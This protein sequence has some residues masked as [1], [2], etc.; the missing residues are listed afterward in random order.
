[1]EAIYL[2]IIVLV[3]LGFTLAI[4]FNRLVHLKNNR[5]QAFSDIDVGLKKRFDLIPNLVETVK[6]YA[7]H[8]KTIF[9]HITKLRSQGMQ[10]ENIEDIAQNENMLRGTLK[11]LFAVAEAYPDL[12]A[13]TNFM[14]LQEELAE[15]ENAL[16]AARRFFNHATKEYNAVLQSFPTILIARLFGF[17]QEDFFEA[18]EEE[19]NNVTISL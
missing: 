18:K 1:M 9:E 5:K 16:A 19:K 14:Q 7:K 15:V 10:S 8:E 6:G 4:L 3:V 13:N 11:S 2:L 12:Q 17:Q